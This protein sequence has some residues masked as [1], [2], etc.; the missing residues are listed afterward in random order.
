MRTDEPV[1]GIAHDGDADGDHDERLPG[2]PRR[3]LAPF[4]A[5]G[6]AVV[7]VA[8]FVLL[9]GSN[10]RQNVETADTP[11][12]GKPAPQFTAATI[13]GSTFDLAAQRGNV[14]ILNFFASNC[15]PC[16]AEQPELVK[17]ANAQ[18]AKTGGAKLVSVVFRDTTAAV[19]AFFQKTGGDWPLINDAGLPSSFG[20]A[21]VPETFVIDVNG[22]V[23]Y[24]TISEMT[25]DCLQS[26]ATAAEDLNSF[27][28]QPLPGCGQ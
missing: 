24:H 12:K 20:V 3:R 13:N 14:V 17:F 23:K 27:E 11:L 22:I 6:I 28:Y 5:L 21:Q 18:S 1:A 4:V 19:T 15:A 8:L 10:T 7:M 25:A 9:A 26:M 2:A 16:I